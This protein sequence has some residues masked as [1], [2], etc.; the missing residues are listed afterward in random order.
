[1]ILSWSNEQ[2][3]CAYKKTHT[4]CY[5]PIFLHLVNKKLQL[6]ITNLIAKVQYVTKVIPFKYF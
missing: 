6:I 2:I 4:V 5:R 3:L 1:M